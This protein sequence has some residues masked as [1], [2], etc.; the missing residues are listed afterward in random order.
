MQYVTAHRQSGNAYA[1]HMGAFLERLD[2]SLPLVQAGLGGGLADH[3][4]AAAVSSAGGLGTI[5]MFAPEVLRSEITSARALTD[6]PIAVNLLLPFVRR[7]HLAA[8]RHA[9]VVTTF[10][11]V[12]RRPGP[13]PWIHQCGSVEEAQAAHSAGAD[14][15]IVQGVEAGGHVRGRVPSLELLERTVAA[16]PRGYSVLVAGGIADA[17]DVRDALAAGATAA[18]AGTR[19]LMSEESR[20][21]A[22]YKTRLVNGG[23]TLLTELFGL[24]WPGAHR[25]LPNGATE[26]WLGH[27][28]RGPRG[29]RVLNRLSAPLLARAPDRAQ[30]ILLR[31]QS[32]ALPVYSPLPCV[33]GTA[34]RL[35]EVS[36]L[37][38]GETVA[39]IHDIAPAGDLVRALAG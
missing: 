16:L 9:D 10:W 32:M 34:E 19:F 7:A 35:L 25:V 1:R 17:A 6:G 12:P 22:G 38:A 39:R 23:D 29:A 15:V 14:A 24:G 5:G 11:G 2:V 31:R 4:L 26:R 28:V 8:A 37:Y 18:V 30:P 36:P 20:A 13:A 21:S 33:T 3:R 27:D